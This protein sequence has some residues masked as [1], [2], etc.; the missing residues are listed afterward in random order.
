[1]I[2]KK[3]LTT[4]EKKFIWVDYV[5]I[6][7]REGYDISKLIFKRPPLNRMNFEYILKRII[8]MN[9]NYEMEDYHDYLKRI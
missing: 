8:E 2:N 1:M 3:P 9:N 6:H 7:A 4:R 5:E